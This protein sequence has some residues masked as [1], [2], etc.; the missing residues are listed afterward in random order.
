MTESPL[1]QYFRKTKNTYESMSDHRAEEL[2]RQDPDAALAGNGLASVEGDASRDRS[3]AIMA[4]AVEQPERFVEL[5]GRL[6][7]LL[8]DILLQR[9]LLGRTHA[10]IA[11]VL[12]MSPSSGGKMGVSQNL[13]LAVEG[14][15]AV[16]AWGGGPPK[17]DWVAQC[18]SRER[19]LLEAYRECE[20]LR[21]RQRAIAV[22]APRVGAFVLRTDDPALRA[23]FAPGTEEGPAAR[24]AD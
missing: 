4:L 21:G 15:C 16:I 5:V 22:R 2:W 11:G 23:A 8:Q 19:E 3:K 7:E 18:S 17:D 9:Y 20:G 10:Q 12:G 13:R 14:L 6:P 1:P 24:H